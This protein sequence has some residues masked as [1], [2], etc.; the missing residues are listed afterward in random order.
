MYVLHR[1]SGVVNV[2]A[3]VSVSLPDELIVSESNGTVDI[4]AVVE[5]NGTLM[6]Q[7]NISFTFEPGGTA[8]N[9]CPIH[10]Y[11]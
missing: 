4:C 8:S 6:A 2:S 3:D 7:L 11:Q 1:L 5:T 9:Y 10:D